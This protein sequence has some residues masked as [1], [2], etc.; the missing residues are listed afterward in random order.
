MSVD[1][2]NRALGRIEGKLDAQ[3]EDLQYLTLKVDAIDG[4]L[5]SV[6]VRT[7][8]SASAI[9]TAVSVGVSLVVAKMRSIIGA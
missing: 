2:V 3:G 1:N 4:R 9:S 5:R 6:E 8:L 7:A